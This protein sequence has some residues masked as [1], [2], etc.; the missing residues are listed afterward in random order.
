LN[1]HSSVQPAR[2]AIPDLDLA[3]WLRLAAIG[4]LVLIWPWVILSMFP[5]QGLFRRVAIDYGFY[6]AQSSALWTGQP[7]AIYSLDALD[8]AIQVLTPYTFDPATPLT[9]GHVPY[10]PLFAWLFTPL[11]WLSPP[12]GF[13][14][15][16]T[17][18]LLATYHLARRVSQLLG[19]TTPAWVAL[20]LLGWV[21][22]MISLLVGQPMIL[23]ACAV[24]ELYLCLRAGQDLRA[25]LWL[26]LLLFK[27]QYGLLLGCLLLFKGRWRAVGGAAIGAA[28]M[29]AGSVLVAGLPTLLAYPN[30]LTEISTFRD[31][32]IHHAPDVMINWR[33]LVMKYL[34]DVAPSVGVTLS[35]GLGALTALALVPAWRGPWAPTDPSFARRMALV[36]VATTLANYHSHYH[37]A[38]LLVVP[39]A[40]VLA[41]R[42]AGHLTRLTI[43]AGIFVPAGMFIVAQSLRLGGLGWSA[44]AFTLLTIVLFVQLL[45]GLWLHR[46]AE[47]RAAPAPSW[48]PVS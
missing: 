19:T 11:T 33:A 12:V 25:G 38:V 9:A 44:R 27:P 41:D 40:A 39:L 23:L 22:L 1:V 34:P 10:P 2:F 46:G 3:W 13:A 36:L 7:G 5:G 21:P 32:G 42:Q 14:L 29:V 4:T 24:A 43:L 6:F 15:W 45:A 47:A 26:S 30:A 48:A 28:A 37:G 31:V 35:V 18:N 8:Q 20:F 16:T 17:I